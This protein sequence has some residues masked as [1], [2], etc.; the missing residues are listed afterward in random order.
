MSKYSKYAARKTVELALG[1]EVA[2]AW[3]T[4]DFNGW[5][6]PHYPTKVSKTFQPPMLDMTA[7]LLE[8]RAN[9]P[10]YAG[11]AQSNYNGLWRIYHDTEMYKIEENEDQWYEVH[12]DGHSVGVELLEMKKWATDFIGLIVSEMKVE[13][14]KRWTIGAVD[15]LLKQG[16]PEELVQE[17]VQVMK[18]KGRAVCLKV[19]AFNTHIGQYS[20]R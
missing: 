11:V 13:A 17:L 8:Q 18:K 16:V 9:N 3:S 2:E 12:C 1:G 6:N 14:P 19:A 20:I 7:W 5:F 4:Q 15:F 10:R